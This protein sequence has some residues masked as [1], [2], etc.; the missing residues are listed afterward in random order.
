MSCPRT[1]VPNPPQRLQHKEKTL[2][3]HLLPYATCTAQHRSTQYCYYT[4]PPRSHSQAA[5]PHENVPT[6]QCLS[7]SVNT[8]N[9]EKIEPQLA[10]DSTISGSKTWRMWQCSPTAHRSRGGHAD[11]LELFAWLHRTL[12]GP[13]HRI[14]TS[15]TVRV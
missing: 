15:H 2:H 6:C 8:H 9:V 12:S 13:L 7:S 10:H 1:S 5:K 4:S 14:C 11:D 3:M